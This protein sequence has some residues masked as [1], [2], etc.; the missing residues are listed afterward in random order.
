LYDKVVRITAAFALLLIGTDAAAQDHTHDDT[1][2]PWSIGAHAVGL[3][4]HA[5]PATFRRDLTEVYFTQPNLFARTSFVDGRFEA[6]T[7]IN[8]EGLT[9]KRGELNAGAWGEGYI[10]RRHPHTYLHELIVTGRARAAGFDVS[11]TAGRGFAP[12]G[13]DDPMARPFVK[14]PVNHHLAQVLERWMLAAAV[15]RG[16]VVLEAGVF[17]GDE[18]TGPAEFGR[19]DRFG[20]SWSARVTLLPVQGAELFASYAFVDSPELA[21]GGGLD[22]EKLHA[23]VR[24]EARLG[25]AMDVYGLIEWMRTAD[26]QFDERLDRN[27]D[28][29]VFRGFLAEAQ[30]TRGEW[31]AAARF[32]R[33]TRPEE[34]RSGD[35]FRTPTPHVDIRIHGITRFTSIAA[36]AGREM[37]AR[38][39]RM[40]PFVEVVRSRAEP[41]VRPGLLT[42]NELWGT[43]VLWSLS[44]GI[45]LGIGM[46][47]TRMGRYGVARVSH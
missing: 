10:D 40:E 44:A 8:F 2:R 15:R 23:G 45:R 18:P 26:V 36:A 32:E 29:Y 27:A 42:P 6:A 39:V 33:A 4:T 13:S 16:P 12:F 28:V 47:H 20:D 24:Y 11:L 22:Q 31:R 14:F 9:L 17:N 1:R 43:D 25:D 7:T 21:L 5:S 34:E 46:N 19:I 41:T 37:T 38:G 3:L 35:P 30:L